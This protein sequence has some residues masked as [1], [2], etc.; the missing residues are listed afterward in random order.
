[1]VKEVLPELMGLYVLSLR[2]VLALANLLADSLKLESA[3]L[4]RFGG[5]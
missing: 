2:L 5:V 4:M 3:P 1:M